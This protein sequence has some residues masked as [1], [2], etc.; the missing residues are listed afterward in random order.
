MIGTFCGW[1]APTMV[2]LYDRNSEFHVTTSQASWFASINEV[3]RLIG[4]L[5]SPLLV[6]NLGRRDTVIIVAVIYF[7]VW[8]STIFAR[9]IYILCILRLLFGLGNGIND[10]V[11][12][13]YTTENCSANFRGII[14]S[15]V[16]LIF[17]VGILCECV[18]A[19][20]LSFLTTAIVNTV[21][22]ACVFPTL[23]FCTETPYFLVMKGKREK[24]S[25]N[26]NWLSGDSIF[27]RE[28]EDELKKIEKSI[29]EEKLKK[30]SF[31]TLFSS[32]ANLKGI[33]LV[34]SMNVLATATGATV[35][36]VYSSLIF[37]PSATLTTKEFTILFT[38]AQLFVIAMSPFVI[39]KVDRRS[40]VIGGNAGSTL[41]NICSF[42]LIYFHNRGYKISYYPWLIFV[43]ITSYSVF[44]A[45]IAPAAYTLKGE[46]LPFSVRAIGSSMAV[47][48]FSVA[49]FSVSKTFLPVTERFGMETNFLGY[50]MVG[51]FTTILLYYVLPETR[52]K[53][54]HELQN[55]QAVENES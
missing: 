30:H 7:L 11:A 39:E 20:Y 5:A 42:F 18:L 43:S 29:E 31:K 16:L 22:A 35:F 33:I 28:N 37:H 54:L 53:T 48:G 50:S 24:A 14:G 6:D 46:L 52:G 15:I 8:S 32:P 26:L 49:S 1:M 13:I 12:G 25:K 27:D 38:A 21:V 23:Y 9:N 51:L 40:L 47:V 41:S 10:V 55:S 45:F 2:K 36:G 34:V 44:G 17:F 3:G 4:P 19:T